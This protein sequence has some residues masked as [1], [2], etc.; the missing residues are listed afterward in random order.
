MLQIADDQDAKAFL[1][2]DYQKYSLRK[3]VVYKKDG[4]IFGGG[5]IRD[6]DNFLIMR[7]F[8]PLP[9]KELWRAIKLGLDVLSEGLNNDQ[10]IVARDNLPTSKRVLKRLGFEFKEELNNFFEDVREY[11]AK[12]VK[13]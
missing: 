7:L 13:H 10:I 12:W 4:V 5:A 11:Y 8:Y 1:G 6:V 9:K 2:D 3:I